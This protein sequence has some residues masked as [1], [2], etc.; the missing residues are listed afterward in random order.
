MVRFALLV[1]ALAS[2]LSCSGCAA[3]AIPPAAVGAAAVSG[4]AGG[5]VRAGTEYTMAGAAYRTFSSPVKDVYE[6]V[7]ETLQKLEITPTNESFDGADV[8]IHGAAIDRT[9]TVKL[10]PITPALT[11]MKLVVSQ[12][13]IGK[14]RATAGEIIS[15]VEQRLHP[16]PSASPPND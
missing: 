3:I 11:R 4:S 16:A 14:D 10:D 1:L 7:H 13:G 8:T 12:Y 2:A 15:Q 9:F 5:L 6:A